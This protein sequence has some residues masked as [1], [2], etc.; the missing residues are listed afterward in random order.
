MDISD[1][2]FFPDA[3]TCPTNVPP[4]TA[5]ADAAAHVQ[6]TATARISTTILMAANRTRN[7]IRSIYNTMI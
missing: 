6:S 2:N 1:A 4:S 7:G 3:A 5:P